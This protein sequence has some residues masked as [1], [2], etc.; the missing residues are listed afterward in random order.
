MARSFLLQRSINLCAEPCVEQA[1]V[2]SRWRLISP[3]NVAV[4]ALGL[5]A[6]NLVPVYPITTDEQPVDGQY[7]I[8][9][10]VLITDTTGDGGTVTLTLAFGADPANLSTFATTFDAGAGGTAKSIDFE[11][12][13]D[14][15]SGTGQ[16]TKIRWLID[17][18]VTGVVTPQIGVNIPFPATAAVP[19]DLAFY[20]EA[21][22]D[23]FT[24]EVSTMVGETIT[25]AA[26]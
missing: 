21:S 23:N 12:I 3:G 24:A 16:V 7:T 8:R 26:P 13:V 6:A 17:G 15:S 11:A 20:A 22:D 2:W 25:A 14:D 19:Y 1:S 5:V 9:G 18:T 4:V 10:S